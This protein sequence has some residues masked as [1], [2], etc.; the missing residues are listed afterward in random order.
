[1][2]FTE[3]F[4][5]CLKY[6]GKQQTEIAKYCKTSRQNITNFKA[7]R[8]YPSLETLY[9]LCE[10]LE[11]SADWLL[12]LENENGVKTYGN[13]YHIGTINNNGKMEIK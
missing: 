3:R 11:V 5:E 8:T 7:G 2:K 4:N 6:S 1:M 12:G 9:L 13:K 10:C